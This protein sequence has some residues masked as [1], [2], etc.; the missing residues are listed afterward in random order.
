MAHIYVY[1]YIC[2]YTC[3][4]LRAR[5]RGLRTHSFPCMY[6]HIQIQAYGGGAYQ[7]TL[8]LCAYQAHG[9]VA[10]VDTRI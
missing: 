5:A 7:C 4:F 6:I 8:F 1:I 9:P 3:Y 2:V 10:A